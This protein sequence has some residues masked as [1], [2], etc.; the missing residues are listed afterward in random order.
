MRSSTAEATEKLVPPRVLSL[1][2]SLEL[3]RDDECLEVTP[4]SVRLR[5]VVL[6]QH[7]RARARGREQGRG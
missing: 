6:Q 3:L 5:K 7:L 4:Q 2:Q 1:E